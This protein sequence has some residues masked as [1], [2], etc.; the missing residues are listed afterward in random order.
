[1]GW[2]FDHTIFMP[3]T[4]CGVGWSDWL[5]AADVSAQIL[6]ALSYFAIGAMLV[7]I[8]RKTSVYGWPILMGSL[9]ITF[10]GMTHLLQA[11]MF[12]I[13]V[14]R[15]ATVFDVITAMVSVSAALSVWREA[16]VV[17]TS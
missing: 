11:L 12:S 13:P 8:E 3:R 5:V 16:N 4:H 14:Y 2:I 7:H 10:C 9:F 1:M 17:P 6:I 15:L